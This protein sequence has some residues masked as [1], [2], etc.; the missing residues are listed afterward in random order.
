MKFIK[1]F[2]LLILITVIALGAY[3]FSDYQKILKEEAPVQTI[4]FNELEINYKT[5][6]VQYFLLNG[7]YPIQREFQNLDNL[8][9]ITPNIINTL[10]V[11]E[12][13]EITLTN[14]DQ[15]IVKFIGTP[16]IILEENGTYLFNIKRV[17]ADSIMYIFEF[18]VDVE[19]TPTISISN[20]NP[21]QG[22]LLI[23]EIDNI[24]R[25]SLIEIESHFRPSAVI[26][27]DYKARFYLPMAYREA[28]KVYPLS[29]TINDQEYNYELDVKTYEF[30]EIRFTVSASVSSGTVGNSD[31]VTQYRE[32]IYPLYET[33][34]TEEY[35]EGNFIVPVVGARISSTFGEMRY[36]NNATTPSRH[37]G[38][39]YAVACGTDVLASN[40]GKVEYAGFLIMIGNTIVI[41]H[42]LGLKTFYEHMQDITI[43]QGDMVEKGQVIGHV[44]TTGYSTG[45]H[46]HF[47][48]MVKNQSI[49]PDFLFKIND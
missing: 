3:A 38:I 5:A 8:N 26:Q 11:L 28:A 37:A 6:S 46:L 22:E 18:S 16:Q 24:Q 2:I 12:M 4:T 23:V 40:A 30:K 13:D 33:F 15:S 17:T 43:K 49:N 47:Q 29:L 45:C 39:D 25:D 1:T 9:L 31:A 44:G 7:L 19:S 36:V 14:P 42:G 35:W 32:T 27:K 48:G 20:K 10:S 21:V 34:E 41:D